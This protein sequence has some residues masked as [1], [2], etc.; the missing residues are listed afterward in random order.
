MGQ[1]DLDRLLCGQF[2][3][4]EWHILFLTPEI[5]EADISHISVYR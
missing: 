1:A 2:L 5:L 4:L 3:F